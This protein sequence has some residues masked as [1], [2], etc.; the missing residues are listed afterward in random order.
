MLY[1]KILILLLTA[2]ISL[3][4]QAGENRSYIDR[5]QERCVSLLPE[6]SQEQVRIWFWPTVACTAVTCIVLSWWAK[7]HFFPDP[8][9]AFTAMVHDLLTAHPLG[10]GSCTRGIYGVSVEFS[11]EWDGNMHFLHWGKEFA[12]YAFTSKQ[13][14]GVATDAAVAHAMQ[15]LAR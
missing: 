14:I 5:I 2:G 12:E 6:N 1:N 15:S 10:N 13:S 3:Q 7:R 4:L 9:Q 11:P 8:R